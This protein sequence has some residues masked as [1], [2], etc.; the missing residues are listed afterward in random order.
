MERR[1]FTS[2]LLFCV[3]TLVVSTGSEP[4]LPS[5]NSCAPSSNCLSPWINSAPVVD[6]A[7]EKSLKHSADVIVE[8]IGHEDFDHLIL[9][10]VGA[11][12]HNS[13]EFSRLERLD[14]QELGA[15]LVRFGYM[16]AFIDDYISE[17][18]GSKTI[19][20]LSKE[21]YYTEMMVLSTYIREFAAGTRAKFLLT[22]MRKCSAPIHLVRIIEQF[23]KTSENHDLEYV[24]KRLMPFA[25][26]SIE[27]KEDLVRS[28]PLVKSG[29]VD[30]T[31]GPGDTIYQMF[32]EEVFASK[33][34]GESM[35]DAFKRKIDTFP[36]GAGTIWLMPIRYWRGWGNI[37]SPYGHSA[38]CNNWKFLTPED[39]IELA[40]YATAKQKV[41]LFDS[42]FNHTGRDE[43]LG[44]DMGPYPDGCYAKDRGYTIDW[45]G[46]TDEGRM[47]DTMKLN[48]DERKTW[49]STYQEMAARLRRHGWPDSGVSIGFRF[50]IAG[51]VRTEF[52]N[53]AI[54][55]FRKE[56]GATPPMIAE[57]A[58]VGHVMEMFGN[59]A[60]GYGEDVRKEIEEISMGHTGES[61]GKLE[62]LFN[63][64]KDLWA[65]VYI[66]WSNHDE[67]QHWHS[68]MNLSPVARVLGEKTGASR[69]YALAE[70]LHNAGV[71]YEVTS[72]FQELNRRLFDSVPYPLAAYGLHYNDFSFEKYKAYMGLVF[73][74]FPPST[75]PCF[76]G[77]D[78]TLTATKFLNGA[79]PLESLDPEAA[80]D[81]IYKMLVETPVDVIVEGRK[82]AEKIEDE[83]LRSKALQVLESIPA[84][85]MGRVGKLGSQAVETARKF[86]EVIS[87]RKKLFSQIQDWDTKVVYAQNDI[88]CVKHELGDRARYVIVNK[89]AAPED[90][91]TGYSI[92]I[93]GN[94]FNL[95][96]WQ[97]QVIEVQFG[98]QTVLYDSSAPSTNQI[99]TAA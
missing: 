61:F 91:A 38:L 39:E 48:Y 20:R 30:G 63:E 73:L 9:G 71:S 49:L 79:T 98:Q 52:W 7:L 90:G 83:A 94:L 84:N 21:V 62:G 74:G 96:P 19:E 85:D 88:W 34:K 55:R 23:G 97:C 45:Y 10:V 36:Q 68:H 11:V 1:V 65:N 54:E 18:Y 89:A 2:L 92:W 3:F 46:S 25:Q 60:V 13:L 22:E 40:R 56:F 6:S 28:V 43:F 67:H 26:V 86:R 42:V 33:R 31:L 77:G 59:S 95:K 47:F 14:D 12:F 87:L 27:E 44:T 50:D 17:K 72:G 80:A 99:L 4:S 81:N 75:I 29:W 82:L 78:E 69:L 70:E 64:Y 37:Q 8:S 5:T 15:V 24:A 57:W 41:F 58:N 32:P 76:L 93:D 51:F 66:V 16:L 35:L 53:W